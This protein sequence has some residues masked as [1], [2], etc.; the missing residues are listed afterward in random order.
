[1][2]LDWGTYPD[3][4]GHEQSPGCFRCHGGN[5]SDSDGETITMDCRSCHTIVAYDEASPQILELIPD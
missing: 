5:H 4:I 2:K 1:M 3:H